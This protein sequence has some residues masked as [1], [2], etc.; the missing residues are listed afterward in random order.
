MQSFP[1]CGL[2]SGKE[3][4]PAAVLSIAGLDPSSGAGFTADLKVFAAHGL[5]GL[6]CPT[7]LTVQSTQG[8]RRS[9]P[10]SGSLIRDTLA[11]LASDIPIAG[12]KIGMLATGGNVR[13]VAAWLDGYRARP[14]GL[15][16]VLDPVL[17][18]SSG[19]ALLSPD[20]VNLLVQEL[21]PLATVVTPN[22]QEAAVLAGLDPSS[23]RSW[24]RSDVEAAARRIQPHL[25]PANGTVLITGGHLGDGQASDDYL[26]PSGA[27]EGCWLPGKR[28]ATRSTHGTGCALSSA[29]LCALVA[30]QV[31]AEAVAS[32]KRYV[33]GALAAA[34]PVGQ[35][36]GPMHHLFLT[37]GG[38]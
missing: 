2:G 23:S 5:Y 10:V 33:E 37:D 15:P 31:L 26:L 8:V 32:A 24:Q 12:V 4:A 20:A 3:R 28:I 36:N 16:V 6:A 9:E 1:T 30:G 29:L 22:L 38:Q 27:G 18:S 34:Y 21:L 14:G 13:A 11:C 35:G 7:A 17:R 19:A 25:N